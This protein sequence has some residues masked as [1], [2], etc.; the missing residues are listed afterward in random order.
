MIASCGNATS[1]STASS[2]PSSFSMA[3]SWSAMS[4]TRVGGPRRGPS[5]SLGAGAVS[6]THLA[7]AI[8][9]LVWFTSAAQ[10][11]ASSCLWEVLPPIKVKGKEELVPIFRPKLGG[12]ERKTFEP[13]ARG[14]EALVQREGLDPR[15]VH[16]LA[17]HSLTF[18]AGDRA[19]DEEN[20]VI[21]EGDCAMRD[22]ASFVRPKVLSGFDID[23]E[24]AI[25]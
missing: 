21:A 18:G 12:N 13:G 4:E 2:P 10:A 17:E 22:A 24:N 1:A 7:A 20:L 11:C 14:S 25:G 23:C 5:F 3:F 19:V 15:R 6:L 16:H 8:L 9:A